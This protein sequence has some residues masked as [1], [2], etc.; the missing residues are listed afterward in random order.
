MGVL[1]RVKKNKVA[2]VIISVFDWY[3]TL[4]NSAYSLL[5]L[6]ADEGHKASHYPIEER[7]LLR[8]LDLAILIYGCLSLKQRSTYLPQSQSSAESVSLLTSNIALN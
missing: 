6:K 4:L 5:H 8:K 1:A 7:K 2:A 3:R